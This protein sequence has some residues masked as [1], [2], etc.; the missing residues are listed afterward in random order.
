MANKELDIYKKAL[1][2][3][4][5][6]KI[7]AEKTLEERSI[8]LYDT[9]RKLEELLDEKSS[10][11]E[12]VFETIIDAYLAMDLDGNI[13]KMND[14]AVIELGLDD[15]NHKIN[16]FELADSDELNNIA[17][18][19]ARLMETGSIIDFEVKI[20]TKKGVKK[21]V[22][23]NFSVLYK[24]NKAIGAQ[25]IIRNITNQR[26]SEY[27]V[28][29]SENRLSALV[30]NL[31][32]GI[33]LEDENQKIILSNKKF[34]ELF[35]IDAQPKDLFGKYCLIDSNHNKVLFKD[36]L[37]FRRRMN[38]IQRQKKTVIG[39]ELVL[40]NGKIIECN[41]TPI[42][43]GEKSKGYLWTF[44]DVTLKG[45]Y[46]K[47][48]EAQKQKYYN[49]IA[50][51]NLG[52]VEVNNDDEILMINQ[53][54]LEMSGYTEAE[55][56]GKEAGKLLA[57]EGGSEII[58]KEMIKRKR[59]ESNSYELKVNTK[60]NEVR[61]WLISGASNYNA[62]GKVIGS[63]G[64][65]LD[66]TEAKRN[67]NLIEEQRK[68][69]DII[70][71]NSSIGIVLTRHGRI[72]STNSALQGMLGF[73]K[74]ELKTFAI[75]DLSFEEDYTSFMTYIKKITINKIDAFSFL[76]RYKRKDGTA[77]W[78]K[79]SV[80]I[81]RYEDR[82]IRHEVSFIE[83][84]NSER[85]EGMILDLVNNLTKS[86]LDKTDIYD[87][88]SEIVNNIAQYL[89]TNDCV[90][91]LV[92]PDE[93]S[94]EQIASYGNKIDHKNKKRIILDVN[95][96]IVGNV[97]KTA[98]SRIIKD[99]SK[100]ALYIQDKE[101]I[102]NNDIRYSEIT[103][104]IINDGKVIGVIDSEHKNKNYFTKNHLKTLESI[105]SLVAIKLRTALNIREH[106][107]AEE[108][109]EQLLIKLEKSNKELQEYA[110]I[111]SHDLK[112]PLRS[113]NALLSWIKADNKDDFDQASL[114]NFNLI[115]MTLE[116]MDQ[117]ITD[118]LM[119]SSID[120]Y[121]TKKQDID[122]NILIDN[123]KQILF[124]PDNITIIVKNK[125]P[126]VF[127]ERAKMQQLFQNLIGNAIK[128]NNKEKGLVEINF[129][130]EKSF[131]QFSVKDNGLGIHKKYYNSIFK[132]F[133]SL[134]ND[135]NSSGIGLSI[136]KKIVD[137]Y[138]GKVWVESE[139]N[140]STTFYF[141]IKK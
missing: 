130:S 18:A 22:H 80:N 109:N 19:Y 81:V 30:V 20:I 95:Q 79:T 89:N 107:K 117:L 86:I 123:L 53:S 31:D 56:I 23:V 3:E 76:K 33:V 124:I 83:D 118:I 140:V 21:L 136:V 1:E 17:L 4:K 98:K 24:K 49:I 93:K 94:L 113:I 101:Y 132:I 100:E 112:S 63:I 141:T 69:L 52:L 55:L 66:I 6:A 77:F 57:V 82:S 10:E 121:N 41:Y 74:S 133:H 104:P 111:V 87:I 135:I 72:I 16:L 84:I 11:L 128:F 60:S 58:S 8:A 122:L 134:K 38:D 29:E 9:T 37:A 92:A 64:I 70:V 88:A 62:K 139:I 25:G 85:E 14:A 43:T 34:C 78:T 46:N 91:Y 45:T 115:E 7:T 48:L 129:R 44:T 65:H 67:T 28:I 27:K 2:K 97:V 110:H 114:K 13:L 36:P 42:S 96:G 108:Q 68:E 103:V 61:D 102:K 51:M 47:S 106:K 90:I 39:D 71:N 15:L 54:F 126:I 26:A 32:I 120:S 12:G 131:Y 35:N 116:K 40:L 125:L 50:N 5:K 138:Q 59:G 137:L 75:N 73:S 127:G 105:A 119:Y 99:T